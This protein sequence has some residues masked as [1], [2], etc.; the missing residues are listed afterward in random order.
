LDDRRFFKIG[1][2]IIV[3]F[4]LGI[5]LKAARSVLY[6][7]IV[8][9]FAS[10]V[11]E[12]VIVFLRKLKIPKSA[13]IVLVLLGAL[14]LLLSLG[15]IVY[16]SGKALAADLPQFEQRLTNLAGAIEKSSGGIPIKL[17][18]AAWI[19][20]VNLGD[21]ASFVK[22]IVGPFVDLV[23]KLFLLFV[24][25]AFILA[26]RG[27]GTTKLL[28]VLGPA[29]SA[30]VLWAIGNINLEVRRYLV[31]K[32]LMSL[33][34]G[35]IVWA[36][37]EIF[38]VE[39]ALL[40]GFL[41]FLLNFIP[42]VGSLAATVLR[43]GFALFQFGTIWVPLWI[44]LITV[45][46]DAVLANLIEPRVMGKGLGLSPLVILFS[47]LFWGWLWGIPGVIM[48]VPLIAVVKIVCQNVPALQP[49][50]LLMEP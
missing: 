20:K 19:E 22:A 13:V 3:L 25:L 7:F 24:F 15:L 36:V 39:F 14:A 11:V 12:P 43:V 28:M 8:A 44:L 1:V 5:V 45:G 37:L 27:R 35:L 18:V 17:R 2:G 38:H 21:V 49:L 23:S 42:S 46:V 40:F 41:A 50:A 33:V 32:T 4:I 48:A 29:R 31:I 9:V 47:L 10:Y 6:P 26:G 16:S 30:E 34:N